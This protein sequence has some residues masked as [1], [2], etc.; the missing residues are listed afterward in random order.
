MRVPTVHSKFKG[1]LQC[2]SKL[3]FRHKHCFL[4]IQYTSIKGITA[5]IEA[6]TRSNQLK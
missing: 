6:K 5:I 3:R 2:M 4:F 1:F